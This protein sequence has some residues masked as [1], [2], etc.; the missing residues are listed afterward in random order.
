MVAT[1]A[2]RR[3]RALTPNTDLPVIWAV[4]VTR[5]SRLIADVLPEYDQSSRARVVQL[6]FEEAADYIRDHQ[7][8]TPCDVVIA[9][10]SNGAYLKNRVPCPVVLMRA[11]GFDLMQALARA[12]KISGRIGVITHQSDLPEF[13]AFKAEFGLDVQQRSF[14]TEE[15]ARDAVAE[16]AAQ[17]IKAVVGTGLAVEFAEQAGMTGV[18]LYSADT[19]RGAFDSA[20][21]IAR[22]TRARP[23]ISTELA[24]RPSVRLAGRSHN[25]LL[26]SSAAIE[27]VRQQIR[28]YAPRAESVLIQGETGT[29]KELVAHG[30]H[31]AG[32]RTQRPFVA[33]NCGAL[34]ESLLEAEL[35]GYEEGAF[36]GARRGG[37]RGLIE[38]AHGGTLFLDEIG[39][40]PLPLQTR[41]LRVLEQREVLRVGASQPQPVDVRVIA[42]THR[43]LQQLVAQKGFRLDL[44]YRLDV[45]R[46]AL[47][48]LRERLDDLP[49]L[50]AHFLEAAAGRRLRLSAPALALLARHHWL[51]N[52]RELRNVMERVAVHAVDGTSKVPVSGNELLLCAPE[53]TDQSALPAEALDATSPADVR[54]ALRAAKGNKSRAAS[55]LGIS[56]S[57]LWRRLAAE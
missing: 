44:Y 16:F 28:L 21:D 40:M 50:A 34:S 24:A 5:L 12:R 33:V 48:P 52:I 18:L 20:L 15:D 23:P 19:V 37:R 39:E 31:A 53:L 45:L 55:V 42:A 35:F 22:A 27:R 56:R 4:S 51:G 54:K 43:G 25:T 3:S 11:N 38:T 30:L 1:Q 10:G 17:G 14:V 9:A 49:L 29:G 8:D 32:H 57:T 2:Q 6:G 13:S 41:L 26:G 36:T 46:I 7:L 47:P